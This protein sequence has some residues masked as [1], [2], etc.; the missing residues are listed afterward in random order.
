MYRISKISFCPRPSALSRGI[1]V[2]GLIL[3]SLARQSLNHAVLVEMRYLSVRIYILTSR[4]VAGGGPTEITG[5]GSVWVIR[6]H[7][8]FISRPDK[9][10]S[11]C[12]EN[13]LLLDRC[14]VAG[15]TGDLSIVFRYVTVRLPIV[16][17]RQQLHSLGPSCQR[18]QNE[19]IYVH[20]CV[21]IYI[22]INYHCCY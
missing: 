18:N 1:I 8:R 13:E 16:K 14:S 21:Y 9:L 15:I 20:K 12:V 17:Y 19:K 6:C 3:F 2:S 10:S 5:Y 4:P 11:H 7:G 22:Y